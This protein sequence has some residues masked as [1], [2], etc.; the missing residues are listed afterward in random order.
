MPG[1][2]SQG[3]TTIARGVDGYSD[4][5]EEFAYVSQSEFNRLFAAS[6]VAVNVAS[7]SPHN[8]IRYQVMGGDFRREASASEVAQMAAMVAADMQAGAIGLATGLEYEPGIY[9]STEELV[10][11][12]K[13]AADFGGSYSS[14][15]RDEDDRLMDAIREII[16]IGRE[17][18][19]D[20]H[21][22][23]IKLADRA[24]WGDTRTVITAL[25]RARADGIDVT[26]DL[27]PYE[28]WASNLVILFPDR[29][30]SNR[31]TAEF[32]FAHTAAAEDIIFA[33]FAP[34]PEFVGMSIAEVATL[35]ERNAAD[36]LMELA[37]RA[38][39]YLR[40]TGRSGARIIARGMQETD[41]AAFMAWPFTNICSDGSH[42]DGHPRG[43]GA[44]PRV[45]KRFVRELDVL[46][47]A[48]AVHKMTGL[49]AATL[50]VNNRGV[51]KPGAFADLVLFDPEKTADRA[52][53]SDPTAL[54]VGIHKVWVNGVL[55]L[56]NGEPT[57]R[58]AGRALT[59]M[60]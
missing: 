12:A 39:E 33:Y 43:Y 20:V 57:Q 11:L 46:T 40:E 9:S 18:K 55:A 24:L 34:N 32:A 19:I 37:Q 47:L 22:S 35:A 58:Y 10:S 26:A 48:E 56:D 23:H 13:V 6:P 54:S 53:M 14:H 52:T 3:I 50:K 1:V 41:V 28:R 15:L 25:D 51:I 5:D 38:D 59:L 2:L 30:F 16:Q 7:F 21:I 8:S 31:D 27:Y 29:N 44:F 36:T 45:L 17:A 42:D 60:P 4:I 49:S